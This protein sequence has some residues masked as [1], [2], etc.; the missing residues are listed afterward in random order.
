MGRLKAEPVSGGLPQQSVRSYSKMEKEKM[1]K[2]GEF[3][4]CALHLLHAKS[5]RI[6]LHGVG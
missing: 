2:K 1:E 3:I 5:F 6:G 4:C